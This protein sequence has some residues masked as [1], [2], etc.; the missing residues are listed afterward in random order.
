MQSRHKNLM[1]KLF[2]LI[3]FFPAFCASKRTIWWLTIINILC[4]RLWIDVAFKRT[5]FI[6]NDIHSADL[7]SVKF[8][9]STFC[10]F[11]KNPS[12]DNVVIDIVF[13]E[14]FEKRFFLT[15]IDQKPVSGIEVV[16]NECL[17][18]HVLRFFHVIPIYQ[19]T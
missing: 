7:M 2:Q 13:I 1:E 16:R 8:V 10:A 3:I 19:D 12:L 17:V 9:V 5:V 6:Y 14:H 18:Q 4:H 15:R 11:H